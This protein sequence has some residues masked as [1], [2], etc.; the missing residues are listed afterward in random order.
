MVDTN[1]KM[2][3]SLSVPVA[4]NILIDIAGTDKNFVS[5]FLSQL[6]DTDL[7]K[8]EYDFGLGVTII[9]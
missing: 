4:P 3:T 7:K 6:A 1:G 5:A 9:L 8:N 2:A